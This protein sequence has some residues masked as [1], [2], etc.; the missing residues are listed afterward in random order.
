MRDTRFDKGKSC[1]KKDSGESWENCRNKW[2]L[3][4]S[5]EQVSER[6]SCGEKEE[7]ERRRDGRVKGSVQTRWRLTSGGLTHVARGV[8]IESDK[9][10]GA[11]E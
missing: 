8:V 3:Q 7:R 11:S 9:V 2:R 4:K 5:T 10:D 6:R 1:E